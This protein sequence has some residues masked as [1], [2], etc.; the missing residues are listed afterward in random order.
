MLIKFNTKL[1]IGVIYSEVFKILVGK[2]CRVKH[3]MCYN[4]AW[5]RVELNSVISRIFCAIAVTGGITFLG[6]CPSVPLV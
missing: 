4:K 3:F 2:N 6:Y 1:L 5:H